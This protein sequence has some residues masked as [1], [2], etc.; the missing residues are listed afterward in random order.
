MALKIKRIM[1][2]KRAPIAI[3]HTQFYPYWLRFK[4]TMLVRGMRIETLRRH[5][6]NIRRFALWCDERGIEKPHDITKPI[7]EGYQRYLYYYRQEN[8]EPLSAGARSAYITSIKQFFKWLTQE[9]YLLY[10]PASE[11]IT[12]RC[13]RSL[14]S[15]LT[16]AEV[17]QLLLSI[18]TDNAKGI[19]ERAIVELFYSTGIRRLELC[20]LTLEDVS[21]S[22]LTVYVRQGKG[23]KDRI[24]PMGARA[25]YWLKKYLNEV[26]NSLMMDD[27]ESRLFL[28]E[29]GEAYT[30]HRL[31]SRVK[32]LL[33]DAGI[34][35]PGACHLLRHAM[36]THML[37]NGAD[38][39]Y[40][41]AMLGHSD[42][43][44]TQIYTH[45]SIRKLQEIHA[46]TH[47]AKLE[48]KE[49]L[50]AQLLLE[51]ENELDT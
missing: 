47:P 32:R 8:G 22:R 21:L 29:Y 38:I 34:K 17:N 15:V 11:L 23:G 30:E 44:T 7:L 25:V 4:D 24:V 5:E 42:L 6:S 20:N 1:K 27:Q 51:S 46:A 3:E 16:E 14:P 10:N 12:P 43:N 35:V 36:A 40:I 39:R 33:R 28:T 2:H 41:Q 45:V 9:N 31:G 18:N 49:I 13:A 19:K 50:I 26:R 48:S 37:E